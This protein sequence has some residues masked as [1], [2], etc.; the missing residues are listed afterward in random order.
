MCRR[1]VRD[2]AL[3][4]LVAASL[5]PACTTHVRVPRSAVPCA[6]ACDERLATCRSDCARSRGNPQVIEDVRESLCGKRCEQEHE[7]CVFACPG[8]P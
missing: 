1:V 3:A 5:L 6:D 7:D 4:V 8:M 2:R